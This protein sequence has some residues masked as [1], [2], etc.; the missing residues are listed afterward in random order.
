MSPV[1]TVGSSTRRKQVESDVWPG[2]PTTTIR[3]PSTSRVSPSTSGS[4]S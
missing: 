1:I 3:R 2:V 4:A